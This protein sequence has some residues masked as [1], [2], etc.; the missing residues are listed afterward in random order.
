MTT[1]EPVIKE[2]DVPIEIPKPK[3]IKIEEPTKE[4]K[5]M[6]VP[7]PDKITVGVN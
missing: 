6:A 4:P 7:E 1:R 3:P 5:P 2:T